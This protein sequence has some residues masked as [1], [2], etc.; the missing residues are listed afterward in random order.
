MTV[1]K[2]PLHEYDVKRVGRRLKLRDLN[3]LMTVAQCGTMGK[4]AAQLA[5]SQP[6][7]SKSIADLEHTVGVRLFDRSKRGV[8]PT[9]YGRALIK[10]GAAIFD[11]MQQGLK[12]IESLSDPNAG[13]VRIGAT[14]PIAAAIVLPIIDG[15]TRQYPQMRFHVFVADTV[16]LLD[17]LSAR[18][19]D[20]TMTRIARSVTEE[21][22]AEPLFFDEVVVATGARNPLLR[23]RRLALADL[24]G[25][26]WLFPVDGF[27]GGLVADVFRASGLEPPQPTVVTTHGPLRSG[28]LA[29]QRFLTVVAGFSLLLPRKRHDLKALPVKLLNTR[30]QVAI[31]TLK[32]RS[33][34]P[35]AQM[36][37][38]HVRKLTKPLAKPV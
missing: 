13:E 20:L 35:A 33:L 9:L 27:F 30:H 8:E 22:S 18:S 36:F 34:S 3:I 17:A 25:E 7:V 37:I 26:P 4:A 11:E 2:Q 10:R 16:P 1:R 32:S 31:V 5:V 6:V 19:V 38:E 29:T 28:L 14:D 15:L 12:D 24:M 23:K 21:L